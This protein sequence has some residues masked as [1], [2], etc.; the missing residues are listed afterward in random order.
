MVEDVSPQQT[1]EALASRP[2]AALCD[3]RTEAEWTFVGLPDLAEL[4]KEVSL[5]PWQVYPSMAHNPGFVAQLA[6]AGLTPE[7]RIF[8]LCRT[9]GRSRAAALAAE[10]A[11]FPYCYNVADGFEGPVDPAGHRGTVAGWKASDLPWRQ[12]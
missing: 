8:F 5:I 6:E 7:H 10:A 11:G 2:E 9:G 12:R 3:V 4:A 1:W